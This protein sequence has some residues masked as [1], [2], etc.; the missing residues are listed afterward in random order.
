MYISPFHQKYHLRPSGSHPS[1]YTTVQFGVSKFFFCLFF[2]KE[3]NTFIQQ[4]SNKLV[5]TDSKNIYNIR[6]LF[7]III[8]N[9]IFEFSI[10]FSLHLLSYGLCFHSVKISS[11]KCMNE[12]LILKSSWSTDIYYIG[13]TNYSAH[14]NFC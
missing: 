5:K 11:Y 6:F 1:K 8:S 7:Q 13:F 4:R 14:D 3:M 10:Q 9:I 2:S 12:P